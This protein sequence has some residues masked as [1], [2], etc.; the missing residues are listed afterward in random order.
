MDFHGTVQFVCARAGVQPSSSRFVAEVGCFQKKVETEAPRECRVSI[1]RWES[2]PEVWSPGMGATEGIMLRA[3][4]TDRQL[5]EHF[6]HEQDP[7][8]FRCL[9]SRYGSAVHR[10][11]RD[12]LQ[13]WHEAEDA[14]QVTFLVLLRKAPDIGDPEALGGWLRGVALRVALRARRRAGQRRALE[15]T[16]AEMYRDEDLTWPSEG[17]AELGT[18]VR[19][20]L[21][22]LPDSYRQ[23]I[24]LC[25]LEG[26]THQEAARRLDW[27][28]GTV[29]V[30]LVRGRR[31]LRDRLDRR[32]VALG[33]G[34]LWLLPRSATSSAI[35]ERLIDA[36]VEA[37]TLASAGCRSTLKSRFARSLDWSVA[38]LR[39]GPGAIMIRVL[40]GV[41][42]LGFFLGMGGTALLAFSGPPSPEID[43][44][45]L[46]G[47][48]TDI[49]NVDCR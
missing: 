25:C 5:L 4:S 22:R 3:G 26:L 37:M 11:C 10:V 43:A 8:A 44:A 32:G 9:V 21:K 2:G 15:K 12:V 49:L 18:V 34:L 27:P 13:D 1:H 7:S 17:T 33:A 31:L 20:E 47:N 38:K 28:V 45:S 39:S 48:L 36:T 19:A 24:E 14:F 30:R 16:R 29:K 41:T 46:P 42:L 35:S 23:P 40:V 6:V